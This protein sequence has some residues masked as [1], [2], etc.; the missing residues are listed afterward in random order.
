MKTTDHER[1]ID[2]LMLKYNFARQRLDTEI[3]ILVKEYEFNHRYNP[4][5]HTKSRVKTK[6][7]AFEKLK[8]KGYSL[9]MD[10]MIDHVHDMVGM[11]I[12]CSFL[13]DVYRMVDVIKKSQQFIIKEE[14]DYIKNPKD[15]GYISYHLN[16]LVPIFLNEKQEYIEAE[17]QIR[18]LAMDFWASIDHKLKYKSEDSV[19]ASVKE[20]IYHCS[21]AIRELDEK[22]Q[23]IRQKIHPG[24]K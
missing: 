17:I 20:E 15:T 2:K 8:R 14:K 13:S 3:D 11:R 22:M 7:S 9:D 4:V 5:E 1:D 6:E 21:L 12:V 10:S 23:M 18:T 19:E 16:V 24:D